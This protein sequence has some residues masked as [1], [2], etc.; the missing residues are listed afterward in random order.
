MDF[1]IHFSH[2]KSYHMEYGRLHMKQY[3][4]LLTIVLILALITLAG[5]IALVF[6]GESPFY[7][8]LVGSLCYL[9]WAYGDRF[10]GRSSLQNTN[11]KLD[12]LPMTVTFLSHG[13]Q[14]QSTLENGTIYYN[15]L[16]KVVESDSL[17]ALYLNSASAFLVP[18]D[19]FTPEQDTQFRAFLAPY[20]KLKTVKTGGKRW[21]ITVAV[22]VFLCIGIGCAYLLRQDPTTRLEPY[23]AGDYTICLP[24]D[25]EQ[26]EEDSLVFYAVVDRAFVGS[27][28]VEKSDISASGLGSPKNASE[29]L[30]LL[31]STYYYSIS[32]ITT[33][34]N[35]TAVCTF[36]TT[37]DQFSYYHCLA[38][39]QTEDAFWITDLYCVEKFQSL[40]EELFPQ[41]A[42]TIQISETE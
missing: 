24:G 28:Y 6:V 4:V 20:H 33:L 10:I 8:L 34:E 29:F 17:Y 42:A 39:T 38:V 27:S 40:Y 32:E 25:V 31:A 5:S 9:F 7:T 13:F 2:R 23:T 19:A 30:N 14:V 3:S 21:P 12:N 41:W 1:T 36:V 11:T 15:A 16:Q 22:C 18:K 35:G 26:V 37:A